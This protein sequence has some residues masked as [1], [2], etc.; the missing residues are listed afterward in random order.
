MDLYIAVNIWIFFS[1]IYSVLQT[2]Q[3]LAISSQMKRGKN[4]A[5][6]TDSKKFQFCH[7]HVI[8]TL[9]YYQ[10]NK[11]CGVSN[12]E[13]KNCSP[14]LQNGSFMCATVAS[15]HLSVSLLSSILCHDFIDIWKAKLV[16]NEEMCGSWTTSSKTGGWWDGHQLMC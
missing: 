7:K 1:Y 3:R 2:L 8:E 10:L 11:S 13:K 5:P 14:V 16:A 4:V 15:S 6:L 12:Q 9:I